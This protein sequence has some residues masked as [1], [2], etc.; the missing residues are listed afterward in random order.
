MK[1][2]EYR[3]IG[4]NGTPEQFIETFRE[5]L[6]TD[7]VRPG[8]LISRWEK[9]IYLRDK[10]DILFAEAAEAFYEGRPEN[11]QAFFERGKDIKFGK[12]FYDKNYFSLATEKLLD[13]LRSNRDMEADIGLALAKVS[14]ED[15]QEILNLALEK[16]AGPYWKHMFVGPLLESGADIN[17]EFY[18]VAGSILAAAICYPGYTYGAPPSVIKLLY[19]HGAS[20]DAAREVFLSDEYNKRYN[21]K[22]ER[23]ERLEFYRAA[24]EGKPDAAEIKHDV[25]EI[26]MEDFQLMQ[27]EILRLTKEVERLSSAPAANANQPAEKKK[28]YVRMSGF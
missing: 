17:V 18:G 22:G 5:L 6:G 23:L 26:K 9:Q 13:L 19:D 20:F 1:E 3:N 4:R 24:L 27:E 25:V 15:K 10:A 28:T 7:K 11:V 8:V 12:V 2:K 21:G 16:A 14:P